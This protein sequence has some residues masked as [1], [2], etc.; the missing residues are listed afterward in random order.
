MWPIVPKHFQAGLTFPG[1]HLQSQATFQGWV[2]PEWS[3]GKWHCGGWQGSLVGEERAAL[4][5]LCRAADHLSPSWA[6]LER[7][8]GLGSPGRNIPMTPKAAWLGWRL[9]RL[10][11]PGAR[12]LFTRE[13][14]SATRDPALSTTRAPINRLGHSFLLF[15]FPFSCLLLLCTPIKL[16]TAVDKASGTIFWRLAAASV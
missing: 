1:R 7:G 8:Q 13:A 16:A 11:F 9:G 4:W 14:V 2:A 12:S 10:L 3:D 15:F 6:R 5:G